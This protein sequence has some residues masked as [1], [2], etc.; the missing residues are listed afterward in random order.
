VLS[1]LLAQ[2]HFTGAQQVFAGRYGFFPMYQPNG[3]DLGA[4]TA[5]LGSC[6]RGTEISFKPYPCGR[7][8]HAALDA[9][10]E[11]YHRL[12][13]A[14]MPAGAGIAEVVVTTDTKTYNEQFASGTTKRRPTQVVEAQF[15]LPVLLATALVQGR[16]GIGDVARVDNAAVLA[17]AERI[18]GTVQPDAA[19][20]WLRLTVRRTDGRT[21]SQETTTPSGSPEH[22]LSH[23]QLQAK[24]VDCAA[25]AVRPIPPELVEQAI[26]LVEH[27]DETP[28]ATAIVRLF[29][30]A[31]G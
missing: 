5:E 15:S 3:Y 26:H 12:D 31:G 13:C 29:A 23:A 20:G 25:H 30:P 14:A 7:G 1:A 11:L 8:N 4:I 22:P 27:L 18:Q 28:D 6:F 16:V 17:L 24:F 9:A 21:A 19:A 10:L 2:E